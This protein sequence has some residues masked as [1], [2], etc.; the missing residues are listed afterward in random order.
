MRNIRISLLIIYIYLLKYLVKVI[1]KYEVIFVL[2]FS[3]DKVN[4]V[5]FIDLLV[6][7]DVLKLEKWYVF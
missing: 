2:G 7:R 6:F 3:Y 4:I 5:M 1:L